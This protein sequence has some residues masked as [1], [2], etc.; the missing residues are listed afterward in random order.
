[1]NINLLDAAIGAVFGLFLSFL[2]IWVSN[3]IERAGNKKRYQKYNGS[4]NSYLKDSLL[5]DIQ[6]T[7]EL[8]IK[9]N[10]FTVKGNAW[11]KNSIAE[12]ITGTIEMDKA[13]RSYGR[14]YYYHDTGDSPVY[15]FGFYEIQLNDNSIFVHQHIK[16]VDSQILGI[17]R[18]AAYVWEKK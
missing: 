7:I 14:G 16:G 12:A 11:H 17:E 3:V 4:Y 9:N 13:L 6:F 1:M 18:S 15:K 10:V 8:T 2:S 5:R